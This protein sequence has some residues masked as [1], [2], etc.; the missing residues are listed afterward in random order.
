MAERLFREKSI[1]RV[2]SPEELNDYVRVANPSVW[3]LLGS[4]I[5]LLT[6]VCIWGI[7]GRLDTKISVNARCKDGMVTCYLREDDAEKLT[8]GMTVTIKDKEY[9]I[10]K[11]ELIRV[12]ITEEPSELAYVSGWSQGQSGYAIS[13][14][15]EL[16]DGT[17]EA[18]LVVESVSP[19]SFVIN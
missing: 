13:F 15:A 9:T 18:D 10:E 19:I 17:Y 6:G 5:I 3:L 7:F 1:E 11:P 4:V 12:Q 2:S 14:P 16:P 8:S